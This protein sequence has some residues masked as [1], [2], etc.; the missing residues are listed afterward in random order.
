MPFR[1]TCRERPELEGRPQPEPGPRRPLPAGRRRVNTAA[2]GPE[3]RVRATEPPARPATAE[4]NP[5]GLG[6]DDSGHESGGPG[7]GGSGGRSEPARS[8]RPAVRRQR[9]SPSPRRSALTYQQA[10]R[11][12]LGGV[13]VAGPG[14]LCRRASLRVT[15]RLVI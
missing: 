4:P 6:C 1:P 7:R 10:R 2:A 15:G 14:R 5:G 12:G 3:P 13:T 9:R 11:A 8:H